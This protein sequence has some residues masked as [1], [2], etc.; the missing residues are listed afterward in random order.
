MKGYLRI[1]G[2]C[3]LS[4][5]WNL[6]SGQVMDN[7]LARAEKVIEGDGYVQTHTTIEGSLDES[8]DENRYFTLKEG[9]KYKIILVCDNDC[10]D[11][12]LCVHDENENSIDCDEDSSDFALAEVSP[13]WTGRFHAYIEMYD[14]SVDP[15]SYKLV[16][17]GKEN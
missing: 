10:T 6:A 4:V 12:D 7:Q 5:I 8:D 13:K 17:F 16:I 15:C 1:I 14:C 9:W 3:F 2:V 11:I